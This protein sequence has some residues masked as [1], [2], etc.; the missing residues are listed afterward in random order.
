MTSYLKTIVYMHADV[1][2]YLRSVRCLHAE[3]TGEKDEQLIRGRGGGN[4]ERCGGVN[5]G[6]G[7][8]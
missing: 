4:K 2:S 6:G 7:T 8:K 3:V 5:K 1:T